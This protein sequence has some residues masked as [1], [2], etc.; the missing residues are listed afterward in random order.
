MKLNFIQTLMNEN[1][2]KAIY[3]PV[4]VNNKGYSMHE[5]V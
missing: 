1:A 2:V 3:T 5:D 4:F